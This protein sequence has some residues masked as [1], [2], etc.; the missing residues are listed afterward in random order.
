[1]ESATSDDDGLTDRQTDR[2][3]VLESSTGMDW[4][5][6]LISLPLMGQRLT[7]LTLEFRILEF[8]LV[9]DFKSLAEFDLNGKEMPTL[10]QLNKR[11]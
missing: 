8:C 3:C 2:I 6:F 7:T 9:Q 4:E 1:M 10:S 5:L 11:Q